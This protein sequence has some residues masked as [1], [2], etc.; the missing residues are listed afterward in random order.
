M[1]EADRCCGGGGSFNLKYYNISK[2]IMEH[3][4]KNIKKIP[5]DTL[6][7]GCPGCMMRFEETFLQQK[8]PISVKHPIEILCDAYG[9]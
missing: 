2:G 1:E 6:V 9:L 8:L 7:S 4:L 5:A 3:K